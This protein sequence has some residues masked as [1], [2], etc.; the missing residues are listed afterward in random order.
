MK[1]IKP[2]IFAVGLFF[3]L[4][5]GTAQA[6]VTLNISAGTLSNANG[7]I[8]MADGQLIQLIASQGDAVFAPALSGSFPVEGGAICGIGSDDILVKSFPLISFGAGNES[9]PIVF[10][11]TPAISGKAAIL[12]W[13][14]TLAASALSATDGTAYGEYRDSSFILPTSDGTYAL[15][16]ATVSGFGLLSDTLGR[17]TL[18]ISSIPEPSTYA[19]LG[20]LAVLGLATWRRRGVMRV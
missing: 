20:G 2:K 1:K 5:A 3:L 13:F 7:S 9:A 4:V 10:N 19:L 8:P 15:T 12:R 6:T 18:T 17:A 16:F 14:P 11:L